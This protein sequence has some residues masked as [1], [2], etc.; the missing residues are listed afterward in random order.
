MTSEG[1][2]ITGGACAILLQLADP[3][4]ARG[5]RRHS[6]FAAA[7]TRRL[8]HTLT[9][10]SAIVHGDA[11][12]I[13]GVVRDV[14]R[15]HA[16]VHGG[17]GSGAAAGVAYDA[18]EPDAQLWV[19]AT[20]FWAA[21]AMHRRAFGSLSAADQERLLRGFAPIAT[22]LRVPPRAWPASVSA[23]DAWF[24]ERVSTARVTDDAR[25][26]FAQLRRPGGAEWWVRA[27]LPLAWQLGLAMLP[28]GV[29]RQFAP[30]WGRKHRF[31]VELALAVAVPAYRML[32]RR[33]RTLP[34]RVLLRELRR[35]R[36]ECPGVASAVPG[37][38]DQHAIRTEGQ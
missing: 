21:R 11:R 30:A 16:P 6:D 26:A 4:V 38:H 7:P 9:Y 1:I 8:L 18:N 29:R 25:A 36:N 24:D 28:T 14:E 31:V 19:A 23:F 10:V 32:P 3:R 12:D 22:A 34:V 37:Y 15:A 35:P 27:T 13:E 20:L 33:V 17:D 2:V 5:V